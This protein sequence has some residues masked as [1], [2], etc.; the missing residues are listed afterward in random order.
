M[1]MGHVALL[2][3][4]CASVQLE[5]HRVTDLEGHCQ[6][7]SSWLRQAVPYSLGVVEGLAIN[8]R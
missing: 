5:L 6:R 2:P 8:A 3:D 1:T 4:D 7:C